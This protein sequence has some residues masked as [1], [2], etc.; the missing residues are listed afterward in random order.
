LGNPQLFPVNSINIL[1]NT[2]YDKYFTQIGD[3]VLIVENLICNL[4]AAADL[5]GGKWI[6]DVWA[7]H[8]K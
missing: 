3:I 7:Q 5:T 4:P 1:L 6:C 2:R 8:P